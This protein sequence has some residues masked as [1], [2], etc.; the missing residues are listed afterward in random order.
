MN[1]TQRIISVDFA[2]RDL[3]PQHAA[4]TPDTEP[5]DPAARCP[6]PYPGLPRLPAPRLTGIV[7]TPPEAR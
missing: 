4:A 7:P 1:D 6:D 5:R 2:A 3:V